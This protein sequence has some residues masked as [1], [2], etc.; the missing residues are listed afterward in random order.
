[1]DDSEGEQLPSGLVPDQIDA[2]AASFA[3]SL[4][5]DKER[6]TKA[7]LRTAE[8]IDKIQPTRASEERRKAVADF[9][10]GLICSCF[11]CKVFMF[12]SVPL[13]TYLPHGDIDLTIVSKDQ[14]KKDS[15]ATAVRLALERSDDAEFRVK[16]VQYIHAEVKLI[17]CHVGNIVVDISFNQLGGL[18]TLCFLDEVDAVI[19]DNHFF[20]RSII[21]VKAW[22]Y[23]ESQ[24]LGAHHGLISTYALETLVLYIFHVFGKSI[25]GPLEVLL[26]FL[27]FFSKFDWHKY[28]VSLWG[29]V[30]ISSLPEMAAE[31]PR[32]DGGELLLSQAFLKGCGEQYA[33]FPAGQD[34]QQRTFNAKHLNV[35]DP[36]RPGNNLGRSVNQANFNR[37]I[38]LFSHSA[39]ELLKILLDSSKDIVEQL[40]DKRKGFFKRIKKR[41]DKLEEKRPD[42][43]DFVPRQNLIA[44]GSNHRNGYGPTAM[45]S[46]EN[47]DSIR[48]YGAETY[49]VDPRFH[50]KPPGWCS[51]FDP[52]TQTITRAAAQ[53]VG[54]QV[55]IESSAMPHRGGDSNFGKGASPDTPHDNGVSVALSN[56]SST[57]FESSHANYVGGKGSQARIEVFEKP[58]GHSRRTSLDL[59]IADMS[60]HGVNGSRQWGDA[61]DLASNDF[62]GSELGDSKSNSE[63]YPSK[64]TVPGGNRSKHPGSSV[65]NNHV[66]STAISQATGVESARVNVHI[67]AEDSSEGTAPSRGS[68]NPGLERDSRRGGWAGEQTVYR[69]TGVGIDGQGHTQ[70]RVQDSNS[71]G[72]PIPLTIPLLSP[73]VQISSLHSGQMPMHL[74]TSMSMSSTIGHPSMT[75]SAPPPPPPLTM[76]SVHV[77]DSSL[78]LGHRGPYFN[79]PRGPPAPPLPPSYYHGPS[80]PQASG[81]NSNTVN[82]RISAYPAQHVDDKFME[83]QHRDAWQQVEQIP[84][85]DHQQQYGVHLPVSN[86]AASASSLSQHTDSDS[87]VN[88]TVS[89][90]Q[91]PASVSKSGSSNNLESSSDS[92][93]A[94]EVLDD[95]PVEENGKSWLEDAETGS[96]SSTRGKFTHPV[97]E[98]IGKGHKNSKSSREKRGLLKNKNNGNDESVESVQ[99]VDVSSNPSSTAES[100]VRWPAS[101]DPVTV[102]QGSPQM[103][104]SPASVVYP[105]L[106]PSSLPLSGN[107]SMSA[108]MSPYSPPPLLPSHRTSGALSALPTPS[109]PQISS[110]SVI[111]PVGTSSFRPPVTELVSGSIT[112]GSSQRPRQM[113]SASIHPPPFYPPGNYFPS[114]YTAY[115]FYYHMGVEFLS[116]FSQFGSSVE[117]FNESNAA[118]A[119]ESLRLKGGHQK[120]A[121][122]GDKLKAQ[123]IA[124]RASFKMDLT[125]ADNRIPDASDSK[126]AKLDLLKSDFQDHLYN[127]DLARQY[128]HAPVQAYPQPSY[129]SPSTKYYPNFRQ[130][131]GPGRPLAPQMNMLPNVMSHGHGIVQG[132]PPMNS[133]GRMVGN[134]PRSYTGPVAYGGDEQPKPHGGTGPFLPTPRPSFYRDRQSSGSNR[135]QHGGYVQDRNDKGDREGHQGHT[136]RYR[137]VGRGQSKYE[138]RSQNNNM[139]GVDRNN[140]DVKGGERGRDGQ[141][142]Q[143]G[144]RRNSVQSA[145]SA[146]LASPSP[147]QSTVTVLPATSVGMPAGIYSVPIMTSN[148]KSSA[149]GMA[150]APISPAGHVM[151]YPYENRVGS[152]TEPLE[153]GS[154]GPVQ[155]GTTQGGN[156]MDNGAAH[157]PIPPGSASMSLAS[158]DRSS[159]GPSSP[160][161]RNDLRGYGSH[162]SVST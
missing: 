43:P 23:Y 147:G 16:D 12:G 129:Q 95:A 33:V 77:G 32:K 126:D 29:P 124:T 4:S 28:C 60:D 94:H 131:E 38:G 58:K 92:T 120:G 46:Q 5:V 89:R 84:V 97:S 142:L 36:L 151:V 76:H 62:H 132:P 160:K 113:E 30:P 117:N 125:T 59:P 98:G 143:D 88:T 67:A 44:A 96:S 3:K 138:P 116:G 153:F 18:C 14:S 70:H 133:S 63:D 66:G 149:S 87:S 127:L 64:G 52:R 146:T 34:N 22:C 108:E 102:T 41:L 80:F 81:E 65:G 21:L 79:I 130:W 10:R 148:G 114:I 7:E 137:G 110:S 123:G 118:Q 162:S 119:A 6:W 111:Y 31:S 139:V 100:V 135:N 152:V 85:H 8:I 155:A 156:E 51:D 54:N 19:A 74:A 141:R 48:T 78:G 35:V 140:V 106:L 25:R 42:A 128:Q 154:L 40:E 144:L 150:G 115:P 1:M 122:V 15:W 157:A 47:G 93:A 83:Q 75:L 158:G 17:K 90:V 121:G 2:Y 20:K 105:N 72:Q 26:R 136:P 73:F 53:M 86:G 57:A 99:S 9:V 159:H 71:R 50:H 68:A 24:I 103:V 56:G 39:D 27:E 13:L 49:Y 37:I 107:G 109:Q 61:R 112:S 91:T 11:D 161:Q 101:D 82:S 45:K 134:Y 55:Q 104:H 69:E 145:P